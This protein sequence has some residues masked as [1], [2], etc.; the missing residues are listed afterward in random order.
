MTDAPMIV[1]VK[2]LVWEDWTLTPIRAS[3]A[4][5]LLGRYKVQERASGAGWMLVFPNGNLTN[6]ESEQAAKAAAQADYE[7]RILAALDMT[8]D[9]RVTALVEAAGKLLVMIDALKAESGRGI[10]YGEED[11]FRMGE[12]FDAEED[13]QIEQARA[14]L[15]AFKGDAQ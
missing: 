11:A 10:D 13:A 14:A 2:P 12:W 6:R 15:A 9:P 4:Q 1:R 8:P 3:C 5:T 7:A